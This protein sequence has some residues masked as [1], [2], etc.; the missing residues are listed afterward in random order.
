[1]FERSGNSLRCFVH[2]LR[3]WQRSLREVARAAHVAKFELDLLSVSP[4]LKTENMSKIPK[5]SSSLSDTAL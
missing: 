2:F 5:A 4:I 1:M 3:T